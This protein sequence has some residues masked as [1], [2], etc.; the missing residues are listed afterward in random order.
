MMQLILIVNR[1]LLVLGLCIFLFEVSTY[2]LYGARN[3][4]F[5]S[6]LF[7]MGIVTFFLTQV[8]AIYYWSVKNKLLIFDLVVMSAFSG[9]IAVNY[10]LLA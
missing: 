7:A 9:G 6:I 1:V 10:F 4:Y 8:L 5:F 2:I 3:I